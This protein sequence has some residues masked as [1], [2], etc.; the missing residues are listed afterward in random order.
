[1]ARTV[2]DIIRE[3]NQ[4][5]SAWQGRLTAMKSWYKLVRLTNDLAQPN[6]ESVIS[7]DPRTAWNMALWLVTP[8]VSSFVFD[9]ARLTQTQVADALRIQ[10]YC[11]MQLQEQRDQTRGTM[12]GDV[13]EYFIKMVLSTGWYA[14]M[15][16]PGEDGWTVR[17]LHPATVFPEYDSAGQLTTV[18]RKYT[19]SAGEAARK[20]IEEHWAPFTPRTPAA[21]TVYQLFNTQNTGEVTFECALGGNHLAVPV[22]PL[23][24][25]RPPI[26]TGPVGGLPDTGLLS[27]SKDAWRADIGQSILGAVADVMK[28]Y[29]KL[30]TYIQQ[31]IRDTSS[32]RWVDE[33][34]QKV[35][36]A[37]KLYSRG[38]IF[39]PAPGEKIYPIQTPSIPADARTHQYDL[40]SM[41]QRGT[42]SDISYGGVTQQMTA[43]LMSSVTAAS[44][45]TL[46]PFHNGVQNAWG[47]VA[48]WN[49]REARRLGHKVGGRVVPEWMEKKRISWKY[50]ITI[51]GDF[52]NRATS[53][54]MLN[55]AFRLSQSTLLEVLFPEVKSSVAERSRLNTEDSLDNPMLKLAITVAEL[56]AAAQAAR[57]SGDRL[58]AKTLETAANQIEAQA[59]QATQPP[60][61]A[62]QPLDTLPP[63]SLDTLPPDLQAILRET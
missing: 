2:Q 52:V 40:R 11:D 12:L 20:S 16:V 53:A 62:G 32:A 8:K 60:P 5:E 18:A 42:F 46:S 35:V 45:Q 55:P 59:Q 7:S 39:R 4:L 21:V 28:E 27:D 56:R 24:Y 48:T 29:N 25:S 36:T 15:S 14:L 17:A 50:D 54:R 23:P 37:E 13:V 30:L 3:V 43:Y 63:G 61:P 38:V 47:E 9:H 51:P 57:Q 19:I 34:A 22:T 10:D 49:V 58:Y 1:M 6:M 31:L 33:S 26:F 41:I 44:Q